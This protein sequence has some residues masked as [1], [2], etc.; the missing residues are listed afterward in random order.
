MKSIECPDIEIA[1][2]GNGTRLREFMLRVGHEAHFPKHLLPTGNPGGETLLGRII[3]QSFRAPTAGNIIVH[4]NHDN[5][6]L[7][8]A[9]PDIDS[10]AVIDIDEPISP[11]SNF[12][13]ALVTKQQRVLGSAG[14]FYADFSWADVLE[15]HDSNP[16]P[17]TLVVGQCLEVDEGAVF[18]IDDSGRI[19]RFH[20]PERTSE[21]DFINIGIYVFD[22]AQVVFS[23]LEKVGVMQ[24]STSAKPEL[25]VE[26]LIE[27]GLL[28][29]YVL[30]PN[31][32]FNINTPETYSALLAH[33]A[34][35]EAVA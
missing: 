35:Q 16:F 25:I 23:S 24:G 4:A 6:P 5:G 29:A 12:M 11:F 31:T 13:N 9:H 14:D 26:G 2:A 3:R 28:G 1:A 15:H 19:D 20:R 34:S 18:D 27:D 7:V 32:S 10:R 8:M 17:V 33:T 30:P 22:P 21:G